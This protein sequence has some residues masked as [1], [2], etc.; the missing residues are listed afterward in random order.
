MSVDPNLPAAL[1]EDPDDF[2]SE[3]PAGVARTKEWYAYRRTAPDGRQVWEWYKRGS[4]KAA[5]TGTTDPVFTTQTVVPRATQQAEQRQEQQQATA[6]RAT[7]TVDGRVKQW[8]PQTNT[9]DIDLGPAGTASQRDT[10]PPGGKAWIDEEGP[11]GRR[12]GWNPETRAYDRDLG[13]SPSAQAAAAGPTTATGTKPLEGQPGWQVGTRAT[14]DAQGN[15]T[16][17]TYYINPQ[18]QETATPPGERATTATGTKPLEG[19]P[20]WQVGTRTEKDAQGNQTSRTYYINPQG[21][22]TTTPPPAQPEQANLPATQKYDVRRNADGTYTTVKNPNYRPPS[23]ITQDKETGRWIQITEDDNGA[24]VIKPVDNQT[25]IKP[26]DIPALQTMYGQTAQRLAEHASELRARQARGELTAEQFNTA[27]QQA[28]QQA[29]VA[30]QEYNNILDNS[31]AV[32]GMEITQRG[33]T[34]QDTQGRRNF[35]QS[36][37]TTSMNIGSAIAQSAGPGHGKQIAAGVAA[38]MNLGARYGQGLGAFRESPEVAAPVALQQ[39][40]ETPLPGLPLP[41]GREGAPAAPFAGAAQAVSAAVNQPLPPAAPLPEPPQAPPLPATE[42]TDAGG[43]PR[44]YT[45]ASATTPSP[46]SVMPGG[47]SGVQVRDVQTGAT[48]SESPMMADQLVR[49]S[50]GRL[51]IVGS[52]LA[53]GAQGSPLGVPVSA[54]GDGLFDLDRESLAMI[55]PNDDD[56]MWRQGVARARQSMLGARF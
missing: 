42:T 48:S 5:G 3:L 41:A 21:Q 51:Q 40:R 19:Q 38:L 7:V 31:R 2:P 29:S 16:S 13:S 30:V 35:A 53:L 46:V 47:G 15:S 10:A 27:W 44:Q 20:G 43:T 39:A 11:N 37:A 18:G 9:Y 45:P 55:D 52:Q 32:W 6:G 36:L 25:I 8:N 17:S 56:D 4:G 54:G 34:L 28:H 24:P 22:E 49:N 1:I 23:Q 12:L 33:Q 26:A 14:K 50:G